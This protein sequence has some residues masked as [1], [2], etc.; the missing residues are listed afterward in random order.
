MKGLLPVSLWII[1]TL[2]PASLYAQELD[3]TDTAEIQ[4]KALRHVRQ[5]EGLLNLISQPDEYFRKYGFDGLIQSYYDD[6]STY[7]I[8]RD[9]LVVIEDDL[10]PSAKVRNY[11]NLLTIKNYLQAFFSLYEKS[12][13]TSVFFDNYE[14]SEVKQGDFTYVEVFYDSE[15]RNKHRAYP[16]LTYPVRRR[17]ATVKAERQAV[18]WQVAITDIGYARSA[19][20]SPPPVAKTDSATQAATPV[21]A[22]EQE[23][24]DS[25]IASR[26]V[27]QLDTTAEEAAVLPEVSEPEPPPAVSEEPLIG[28]AFENTRRVYRKGKTY[29]LPIRANPTSPPASLMLYRET[30]LVEDLT[31]TL[32]DS[33]FAWQV[34][35]EVSG[36][37]NYQLRLYDPVSQE[38]VESAAFA[39]K[40]KARWPLAAAAVG[41]ATLVYIIVSGDDDGGSGGD[42][43]LPAPPSPK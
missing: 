25:I 6:Q 10:N 36:G 8:F 26:P 35:E 37:D 42:D 5:F 40:R 33:S 18:G 7:Q 13:A 31:R 22:I 41:V 39:I 11:G 30:E 29:P 27:T 21:A 24:I 17:K 16:N 14:V 12:P 43:E 1:T 28:N 19:D 3:A 23:P 34:P 38:V 20:D 2:L 4:Q 32:A 9:S 15:F